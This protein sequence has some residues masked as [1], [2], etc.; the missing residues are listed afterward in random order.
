MTLTSNPVTLP[1][2]AVEAQPGPDHRETYLST[3]A[4]QAS[5]RAY[6]AS[7]DRMADVAGIV[8]KAC[9]PL[10]LLVLTAWV[11]GLLPAAARF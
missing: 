10:I 5:V 8:W 4:D 6:L 9:V 7:A 2:A 11:L 1:A 3:E